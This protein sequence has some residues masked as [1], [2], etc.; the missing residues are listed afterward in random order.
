[1]K[2]IFVPSRSFLHSFV[3]R[4]SITLAPMASSCYGNEWPP[5]PISLA[6]RRWW[7][8]LSIC[9]GSFVNRCPAG[10]LNSVHVPSIRHELSF[11]S[12]LPPSFPSV[13]VNVTEPGVRPSTLTIKDG[14]SDVGRSQLVSGITN[15]RHFR[16]LVACCQTT[17]LALVTSDS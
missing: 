8:D 6:R 11:A 7:V 1:M 15:L 12:P 17:L 14:S 5:A 13:A 3:S 16:R 2:K 9:P 4:M 10:R